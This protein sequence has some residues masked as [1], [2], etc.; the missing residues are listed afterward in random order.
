MAHG[1]SDPV[2]DGST[3]KSLFSRVA[4]LEMAAHGELSKG[5]IKPRLVNLEVDLIGEEQRGGFPDRLAALE[6]LL[7]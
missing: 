5:G 4:A 1:S 3:G 6:S 7:Q 2:K